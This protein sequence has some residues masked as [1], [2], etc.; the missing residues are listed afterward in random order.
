MNATNSNIYNQTFLT[1]YALHLDMVGTQRKAGSCHAIL[2]RGRKELKSFGFLHF[3]LVSARLRDWFPRPHDTNGDSRQLWS[4]YK[5]PLCPEG[6]QSFR[7]VSCLCTGA[8]FCSC[9]L[10]FA[11]VF[12]EVPA[13]SALFALLS[14]WFIYSFTFISSLLITRQLTNRNLSYKNLNKSM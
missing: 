6:F 4:L 5:S 2:A 1:D 11:P 7:G 10:T 13:L 3:L 14:H 12:G 8:P 9:C